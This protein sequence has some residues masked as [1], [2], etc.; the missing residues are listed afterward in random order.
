MN[1]LVKTVDKKDLNYTFL[2]SLN[3]ILKLAKR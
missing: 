3:G 2:D 1:K